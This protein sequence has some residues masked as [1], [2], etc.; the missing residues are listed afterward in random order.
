MEVIFDTLFPNSESLEEVADHRPVSSPDIVTMP[1]GPSLY[2]DTMMQT[3]IKK[4]GSFKAAGTD[5]IKPIV[6]EH[7]D[8]YSRRRLVYIMEASTKLAYVPKRWRESRVIL[9]PKPN[10]E[11]YALVKSWR[12]LA[13]LQAAFKLHELMQK[14][15]L[16]DHQRDCPKS[17][18]QHAFTE[19][20]GYG[21]C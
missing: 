5:G 20:K 9:V 8:W 7:L 13:M 19:G 6:H 11:D 10:R 12:P 18:I 3:A 17:K 4:F 16:D 2:S 21:N 14:W 1:N 15:M